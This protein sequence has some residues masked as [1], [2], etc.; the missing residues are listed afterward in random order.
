M[1]K[2][3][4]EILDTLVNFSDQEF[5]Q[6]QFEYAYGI[7]QLLQSDGEKVSDTLL[8]SVNFYQLED[9]NL[10]K[11]KERLKKVQSIIKVKMTRE[12]LQKLMD[13]FSRFLESKLVQTNRFYD[14]ANSMI[15]M[16]KLTVANQMIA[17]IEW[18]EM[19][20]DKKSSSQDEKLTLTAY[21][22]LIMNEEQS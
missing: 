9:V 19:Q 21:Q 10:K 12:N 18:A 11:E 4:L 16:Q 20:E 2:V 13:I 7:V 3:I 8:P 5:E 17:T 22:K 14:K 6:I 15:S 1:I